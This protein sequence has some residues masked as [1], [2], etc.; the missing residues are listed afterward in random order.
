MKNGYAKYK[1]LKIN[2]SINQIN[3]DVSYT[4]CICSYVAT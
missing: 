1:G 3:L 2:Q 4:V